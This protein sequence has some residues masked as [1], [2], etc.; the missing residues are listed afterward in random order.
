VFL[1]LNSIQEITPI[2]ESS[3]ACFSSSLIYPNLS[4][5]STTLLHLA[6]LEMIKALLLKW[7]ISLLSTLL[8]VSAI[9]L[10]FNL[11]LLVFYSFLATIFQ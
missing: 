3:Y 11:P 8:E 9:L 4:A 2:L 1:S 6:L 10:T 5:K 7:A